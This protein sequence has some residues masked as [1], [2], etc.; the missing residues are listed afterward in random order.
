LGRGSN[1]RTVARHFVQARPGWDAWLVDLR[2]HGSSPKSTPEP[3][4]QAAA[5]DVRALFYGSL[6][7]AALI[8]HS[9]GGKVA[10]ELARQDHA[11][12]AGTGRSLSTLAH[13]MTLDS[14][15]GV[16]EPALDGDSAPA[17]LKMLKELP[18]TFPTRTAFVEAVLAQG[19][20]RTLAQWLAMNTEPAQEGGVRFGLDLAELSALLLS[21]LQADLWPMIENPP[22]ALCVHQVIGERSTSYAP[23]DRTRARSAAAGSAR[24]TVDFLPTDHWIHSEDPEGL[25]RVMLTRI[26]D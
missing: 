7:V 11:D 16:R 18:A 12:A 6:P 4:L 8:G 9:L 23:A 24:V 14:N 25:L 3:S 15:P 5:A 10:L 17:V 2:G 22:A 13:V 1:L 21:Y 26:P 20:S 19:K